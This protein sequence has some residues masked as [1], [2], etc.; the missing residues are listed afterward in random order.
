MSDE[1]V[2]RPDKVL[3]QPTPVDEQHCTTYINYRSRL[4]RLNVLMDEM[5]N[6]A[7]QFIVEIRAADQETYKFPSSF[8]DN[9]ITT[10]VYLN[11]LGCDMVSCTF[12]YP[13][14]NTCTSDDT[15][16]LFKSGNSTIAACQPACFNLF[17]N[18]KKHQPQAVPTFHYSP[19][20][21]CCI[22]NPSTRVSMIDDYNRT[23]EHPTINTDTIGTGFDEAGIYKDHEGNVSRKYAINRY[24][25][26]ALNLEFKEDGDFNNCVQSQAQNV[27]SYLIG[28]HVYS[29]LLYGKD[30]ATQDL[31]ANDVRRPNTGPVDKT[32]YPDI[33][34]QFDKWV[35]PMGLCKKIDPN[36]TLS[37]LGI[38]SATRH[39]IWTNEFSADG[40]L[41][42]PLLVYTSIPI[43]GFD[44]PPSN[45]LK[46]L[47][48]A[49]KFG[50]EFI[51]RNEKIQTI[52]R[53]DYTK[54]D[55]YKNNSNCPIQFRIADTGRRL[56]Q[57]PKLIQLSDFD[58][59]KPN[60]IMGI[61]DK[62]FSE[63]GIAIFY[64]YHI[65]D[66]VLDYLKVFLRRLAKTAIPKFF[67]MA[68]HL[69]T[70]QLVL[71]LAVKTVLAH[72]ITYIAFQVMAKA[73]IAVVDFAVGAIDVVNFIMGVSLIVDIVLM[74]TDPFNIAKRIT[75]DSLKHSLDRAFTANLE[76]YKQKTPELTVDSLFNLLLQQTTPK[77][78]EDTAEAQR[79][80]E[81]SRTHRSKRDTTSTT[82]AESTDATGA[83]SGSGTGTGN[84]DTRTS[85]TGDL[86]SLFRNNPLLLGRM[87]GKAV[88]PANTK[89]YRTATTLSGR[90]TEDL[91]ILNLA[92]STNFFTAH[93]YN[94]DGAIYDWETATPTEKVTA[95]GI[96]KSVDKKV[97][98][99][100]IDSDIF[101]RDL[102]KRMTHAQKIQNAVKICLIG[103]LGGVLLNS[104][105]V[106]ILLVAIL[107]MLI[108]WHNY[109]VVY[110][111][112]D[113]KF[114]QIEAAFWKEAY[115]QLSFLQ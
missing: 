115:S 46:A 50:G 70:R 30:L 112:Q 47:R 33:V 57:K 11:K 8:R 114:A 2:I 74:F 6:I 39:M 76:S 20:Q 101:S 89:K 95:E 88:R 14:G 105:L 69:V 37:Q 81:E 21:A 40:D 98:D 28:E 106:V 64:A 45:T 83:G 54:Y 56:E 44:D 107:I 15:T 72:T 99:Q 53:I 49:V 35:R 58:L 32:R 19:Y 71:K 67:E 16:K 23:D 82:G 59:S 18:G 79:Q 110:S 51:N 12:M 68:S 104:Q 90:V 52:K 60:W 48:E 91:Q 111:G 62:L 22:E 9:A 85:N 1:H 17:K 42:E 66:K 10:N 26:D 96:G 108:S 3:V 103:T 4:Y 93:K 25:C 29:A 63:E 80:E 61:I 100:F 13:R 77:T 75:P 73:A 97:S 92:W 24:Y 36:I 31:L 109:Y 38:T 94:S 87:N 84:T 113:Q 65:A 27:A 102:N 41:V 86:D 43:T 78:K 7:S 55:N 34:T 5:P